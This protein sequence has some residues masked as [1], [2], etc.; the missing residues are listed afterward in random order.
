MICY[1]QFLKHPVCDI[2]IYLYIHINEKKRTT[3]GVTRGSRPTT[4]NSRPSHILLIFSS[5]PPRNPRPFNIILLKC[6]ILPD[7]TIFKESDHVRALMTNRIFVNRKK[8]S[9]K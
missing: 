5:V 8:V 4:T 3:L 6:L 7:K 2:C 1:V 9:I